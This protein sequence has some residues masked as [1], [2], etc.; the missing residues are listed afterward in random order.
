MKFDKNP[1]FS[2]A[3]IAF[4]IFHLAV[5][6]HGVAVTFDTLAL[7]AAPFGT[8][9]GV[10]DE[11]DRAGRSPDADPGRITQSFERVRAKEGAPA[12]D[13]GQRPMIP[14]APPPPL[15]G[16]ADSARVAGT[17]GSVT[18]AL[19]ESPSYTIAWM[20]C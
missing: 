1:L 15:R 4:A 13:L 6:N 18:P 16:M 7:L 14:H 5:V 8:H 17:S 10:D 3:L 9:L 20:Q 12:I 19:M 2:I 11:T